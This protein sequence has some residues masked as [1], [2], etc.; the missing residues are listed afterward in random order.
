[1]PLPPST[2]SS[3]RLLLVGRERRVVAVDQDARRSTPPVGGERGRREHRRQLD[4][5]ARERRADGLIDT[6]GRVRRLILAE[7]EAP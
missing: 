4:A 3:E 5:V 7:E 6:G 2:K 1:M